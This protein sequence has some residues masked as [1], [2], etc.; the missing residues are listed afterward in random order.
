[1]YLIP[2]IIKEKNEKLFSQSDIVNKK[3]YFIRECCK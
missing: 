2:N 1:M 3:D